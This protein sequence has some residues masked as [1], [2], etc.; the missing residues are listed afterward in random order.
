KSS[1]DGKSALSQSDNPRDAKLPRSADYKA[2]RQLQ[3]IA[4]IREGASELDRGESIT[5]EE[6][7][8]QIPRWAKVQSIAENK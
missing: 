4:G 6:L 5:A 8:K 1:A 2:G 3:F 7:L